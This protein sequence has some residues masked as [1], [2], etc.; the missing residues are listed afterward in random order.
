[1]T[2]VREKVTLLRAEVDVGPARYVKFGSMRVTFRVT[3][4]WMMDLDTRRTIGGRPW[5][6][7]AATT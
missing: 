7:T 2:L 5:A 3:T 6:R 1:V 4:V